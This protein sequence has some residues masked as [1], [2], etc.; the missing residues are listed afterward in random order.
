MSKITVLILSL[1]FAF[2]CNS[3]IQTKP[4]IVLIMTD[5]LNDYNEDLKGHPQIISPNIK[6]LADSGVSFT[7]AHSNDPMCGPSRS[8]M[9]TGVYPHNSSNFWQKPWFNNDVLNNTK[10]IMEKFKENGYHV[11]GSGKILHHNKKELWSEFEHEAD[12]GPVA[13]KGLRKKGKRGVAHPD[14]E[15]P[16]S[17]IGQIDGS[18]GPFKN[19][20]LMK[21][22]R[23]AKFDLIPQLLGT[24]EENIVNYIINKREINKELFV[25]I[26]AGDGYFV[27]GFSFSE[28]FKN[29]YAFEISD[30]GRKIIKNNAIRN[31]CIDKIE[32]FKEANYTSL[33]EI[34]R[35][36]SG[37]IILIDIEG[38]EYDL[39]N[40]KI[41]SLLRKFHLI[42]E[43]H[44]FL[45]TNPKE[46]HNK[47]MSRVK[48]YFLVDK[49]KRE[50]YNPSKF[51]ELSKFTEDEQLLAL[52]EGRSEK[53]EWLLLSPKN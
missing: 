23:W 30:E 29:V 21:N 52:S 27:V 24:Y 44:P 12:Y 45:I 28:I 25:E 15:K 1:F 7:N 16:F 32:I 53:T 22:A 8:S 40:E 50:N 51:N 17:A 34:E 18:Y 19:M 38:A 9:I 43:M 49:S 47:L 26:G 41:L 3:K 37:G 20:L 10:T 36:F 46:K 6:K 42:I 48:K 11:L 31:N 14:V 33:L 2:G 4:N 5:D 13:Y 35:K 39:L